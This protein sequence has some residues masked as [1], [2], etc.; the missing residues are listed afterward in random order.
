MQSIHII[1]LVIVLVGLVF[2]AFSKKFSALSHLSHQ[3]SLPLM[4]DILK[5]FG[6][7]NITPRRPRSP[8]HYRIIGVV[9]ITVTGLYNLALIL[10]Q[11]YPA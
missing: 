4:G 10:V 11:W 8:R 9:L 5:K 3:Y 2:I 7:W 1:S 6:W